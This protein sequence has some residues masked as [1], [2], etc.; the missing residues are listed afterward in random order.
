MLFP[1][2]LSLSFLSA[3]GPRLARWSALGLVIIESQMTAWLETFV[4]PWPVEICPVDDG[5]CA[6][7]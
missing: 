3:V 1:P 5:H 4:V 2:L 7:T 6:V